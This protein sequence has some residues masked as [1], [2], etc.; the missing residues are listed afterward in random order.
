MLRQNASTYKHYERWAT[1]NG[2]ARQNIVNDGTT[3]GTGGIGA[4][5]DFDLVVRGRRLDE[6]ILVVAGDMHFNPSSFDLDGIL[7]FAESRDGSL[8]CNYQLQDGEDASTRGICEVDSDN[9]ITAFYEKP[10]SGEQKGTAKGEKTTGERR[11]KER[12]GQEGSHGR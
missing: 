11:G 5:A 10:A 9:R 8:V 2:F 12:A 1:A 6:D 3:S 7:R 4:V